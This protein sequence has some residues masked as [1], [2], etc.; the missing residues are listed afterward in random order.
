MATPTDIEY[1]YNYYDPV[2]GWD[3]TNQ[4]WYTYNIYNIGPFK[5]LEIVKWLYDMID[6]PERHA[7]WVRFQNDSAFRFRY[8]RDYIMFTLRW[9]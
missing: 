2:R 8:E 9:S 5:H 4:N 1:V 7:R 3:H 6:N